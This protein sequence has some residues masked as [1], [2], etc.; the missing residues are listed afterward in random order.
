[1]LDLRFASENLDEVK[2]ALTRRGFVEHGVI[3]R[4]G[5]LAA[6]RRDSITEVDALR[7]SRNDASQAMANVKDKASADFQVK[8]KEL[9][10]LGDRIKT[11][12]ARQVEVER[13]LAEIL[14]EKGAVAWQV[15]LTGPMGRASEAVSWLLQPYDLLALIP[16]DGK[17]QL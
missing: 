8:R 5:A 17:G 2:T 11:A 4:L 1:M 10:S 6:R 9:R 7:Q 12:E 15:Q 13:E 3:D 16:Q 14:L